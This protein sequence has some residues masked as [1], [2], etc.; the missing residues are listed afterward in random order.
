MQNK[1]SD[2]TIEKSIAS[3]TC[4]GIYQADIQVGFARVVTDDATMYWLCDVFIHEE[5]R[6]QGLGKKLIEVITQLD[7][8]RDLMGL[9]GTLDAHELYEQYQFNRNSDRFMIRL[10]DS[11]R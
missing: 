1:R 3:S 5:C 7:R 11:S 4:Y 8:F 9:L 2:E 10:P 6:G